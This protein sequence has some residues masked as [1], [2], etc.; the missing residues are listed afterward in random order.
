MEAPMKKRPMFEVKEVKKKKEKGQGLVK[1]RLLSAILAGALILPVVAYQYT[2]TASAKQQTSLPHIEEIKRVMNTASS[3]SFHILEVTP[4]AGAGTREDAVTGEIGYYIA[5]QEPVNFKEMLSGTSFSSSQER[6]SW[7]NG[8]LQGLSGAG[9]LSAQE[10]KAPLKATFQEG[11]TYYKEYYPWEQAPEGAK[12]LYFTDDKGD[13]RVETTR[14]NGQIKEKEGGAYDASKDAYVVSTEGHYVQNIDADYPLRQVSDIKDLKEDFDSAKEQ[15]IFYEDPVFSK[16]LEVGDDGKLVVPA[17]YYSAIGRKL[18]YSLN[19]EDKEPAWRFDYD[20]TAHNY[21]QVGCKFRVLSGFNSLPAMGKDISLNYDELVSGEYYAARI[22]LDGPFKPAKDGQIGYFDLQTRDL[23]YVGPGKGS[24]DLENIAVNE[25]GTYLVSY[26]HVRYRG[27]YKNNNWFLRHVLDYRESSEEEL[28]ALA[29]KISVDS[30]TPDKVDKNMDPDRGQTQDIDG[31]DLIVV[32]NGI[33]VFTGNY[34]NSANYNTYDKRSLKQ[35]LKKYL[36]NKGA[37]VAREEAAGCFNDPLTGGTEHPNTVK[38]GDTNGRIYGGIYLVRADND[39]KTLITPNF[40]TN[41]DESQYK[42]NDSGFYDVYDEINH[43]N[44]LR[45]R[46]D[47]NTT[48]LLDDDINMATAMRYVI[49]FRNQRSRGKKERIRILDIE[50]P[51]DPRGNVSNHT[52]SSEITKDSQ[53]SGTIRDRL[54]KQWFS[55]VYTADKI[56]I[57][58]VSTA[59]L[60]GLT[61]DVTEDYDLI[62]IGGGNKQKTSEYQDT[63]MRGLIYYNIGD[64]VKV[65]NSWNQGLYST[66][67]LLDEDYDDQKAYDQVYRYSGNDLTQKKADE[68]SG[69]AAVGL[70][71]IYSKNLADE[72]SYP[73]QEIEVGF[74]DQ[75]SLALQDYGNSAK[76]TVTPLKEGD[77][78]SY[79]YQWYRNDSVVP[80]AT[81]PSYSVQKGDFHNGT[82]LQCW[83]TS[84]A[85]NGQTFTFDTDQAPRSDRIR[86]NVYPSAYLEGRGT[87]SAQYNKTTNYWTHWNEPVEM[88]WN[89]SEIWVPGF[90]SNRAQI[91]WFNTKDESKRVYGNRT[92]ALDWNDG[93]VIQ[94]VYDDRYYTKYSNQYIVHYNMDNSGFWT[95]GGKKNSKVRAQAS[96][97]LAVNKATVDQASRLYSVMT[98]MTG[99]DNVMVEG[100]VDAGKLSDYVNLSHPTLQYAEDGKPMEYSQTAGDHNA[101]NVTADKTQEIGKL[102]FTF[103]IINPTDPDPANTTY[104]AKLYTDNNGD[105]IF[106]A[107]EEVQSGDEEVE[108]LRG[109]LSAES[110]PEVSFSENIDAASHPG[111]VPWKLVISQNNNHSIH[112]SSYGISYIKP[113]EKIKLKILQ[114]NADD[115]KGYN[116]ES[117]NINGTGNYG[118]CLKDPAVTDVYDLTII[119]IKAKDLAAQESGSVISDYFDH[120][121]ML[122]LGFNDMYR[123]LDRK[124]CYAIEDFADQGKSVLFSHDLSSHVNMNA[125]NLKKYYNTTGVFDALNFNSILRC[126]SYLDQYGISDTNTYPIG[127]KKYQFGG[128][129]NWGFKDRNGKNITSG[130]LAELTGESASLSGEQISALESENY[131]IAYKPISSSKTITKETI[132]QTQGFTNS[133]LNRFKDK[134]SGLVKTNSVQQVNSG[135]ITSYP[136]DLNESKTLGVSTTHGQYYQLN[137]NSDNIVVWY[138]LSGKGFQDRDGVNEYYIYSANNITYTGAGHSSDVTLDEAKLFVNTMVA[139]RRDTIKKP[140]ASFVS[141]DKDDSEISSYYLLTDQKESGENVDEESDLLS[142]RIYFKV[143]DDNLVSSRRITV[144]FYDDTYASE[145]TI[146]DVTIYQ[147]K[148]DKVVSKLKSGKI[149]YINLPVEVAVKV[150]QKDSAKLVILPVTHYGEQESNDQVGEPKTLVIQKTGMFDLG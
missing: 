66:S 33:D 142:N 6:V 77:N 44:I 2:S 21:Y 56:T 8:Y 47:E 54:L 81:G 5:G 139:A 36:G 110:A 93:D 43:E 117:M 69:F 23:Q 101:I 105:G 138:T 34:N 112:I 9:I 140:E 95:E 90:N 60:I 124:T 96:E 22:R 108:E 137:M 91:Y 121:D 148:D 111:C 122:I 92:A 114:I 136:F 49:N 15:Y 149:Y 11:N 119:T 76:V 42:E 63:G 132:H 35:A 103:K 107:D 25:N 85:V 31:Y 28:V 75:P 38:E 87:G 24:F 106:S 55:N 52:I 115:Q 116:L 10:D 126:R 71:V 19:P 73:E 26:D 20:A 14:V 61:Q 123:T 86:L 130:F 50:P 120:F 143:E 45:Q 102:R 80:G 58:T 18:I 147:A 29:K 68:I 64:T 17:S 83:I 145:N 4:K 65:P 67:G 100:K 146:E 12:D 13:E 97:G 84:V 135:Q 127:A 109:G 62:Y 128:T 59:T 7:A 51:A 133:L 98:S 3:A 113:L 134:G 141:S 30:L 131:S 39:R 94:C 150:K 129:K 57:T 46:T 125:A 40:T 104:S 72:K 1:R 118:R 37:V 27:G 79:S 99:R 70:P 89:K 78:I 48:D 53:A 16:E 74:K 82:I 32:S 41:F 88:T 144:N